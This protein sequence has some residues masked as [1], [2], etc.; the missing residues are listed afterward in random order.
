MQVS[1]SK[2]CERVS[3]SKLC[4]RMG[5]VSNSTFKWKSLRIIK[6]EVLTLNVERNGKYNMESKEGM[7]KY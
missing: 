6:M 3:L 7:G 1:L 4:E 2:L 5:D